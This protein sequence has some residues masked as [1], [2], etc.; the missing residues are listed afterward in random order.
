MEVDRL[1]KDEVAYECRMRGAAISPEQTIDVLRTRLRE[2][3]QLERDGQAFDPL[4]VDIEE[5]LDVCSLKIG[6]AEFGMQ[7][8]DVISPRRIR[9]LLFHLN[10][11]LMHILGLCPTN[12]PA[13]RVHREE[14]K[15]LMKKLKG[16]SARFKQMGD[17]A[18]YKAP[19]VVSVSTVQGAESIVEGPVSLPEFR[20]QSPIVEHRPMTDYHNIER[21]HRPV[22]VTPGSGLG[23]PDLLRLQQLNLED[24]PVGSDFEDFRTAPMMPFQAPPVQQAVHRPLFRAGLETMFTPPTNLFR[25][26]TPQHPRP[27]VEVSQ[28]PT[29][30]SSFVPFHKW[31]LTFSGARDSSVNAFLLRIEELARSRG[32]QTSELFRAATEFFTGPALV[33]YRGI[34]NQVSSWEELKNMLKADFLPADYQTALYEE[35]RNRKQGKEESVT[36]FVSCM[37]GLFG[38]LG[39]T[40]PEHVKLE[41]ILRNLAPFYLQNLQLDTVVSINHLKEMAKSLEMKKVLIEKYEGGG[42]SRQNFLEPDLAAKPSTS[43]FV[44]RPSASSFV[45]RRP[46]INEIATEEPKEGDTHEEKKEPEVEAFSAEAFIC[47][48]CRKEGHRFM[49][50][51]EKKNLFCHKCGRAGYLTKNCP[52]CCKIS[53]NEDRDAE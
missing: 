27:T 21:Q 29:Q 7:L 25:P 32:V 45:P 9:S 15:R 11:R 8:T 53:G 31:G 24:L 39:Y 47:Y 10:S 19:S 12:D 50:C 36:S 41:Q 52:N 20:A 14:A 42:R 17:T 22:V 30:R 13:G 44:P 34:Q 6:E 2:F 4:P 37:I 16:V 49:N 33:W 18:E 28:P 3:L 5:E 23:S 43:G 1:K 51:T 38:R 26:M 48:N 35:I 46:V 40:V